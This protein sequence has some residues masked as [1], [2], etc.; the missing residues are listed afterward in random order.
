MKFLFFP[1]LLLSFYASAQQYKIY[2]SLE[3]ALKHPTEVYRLDLRLDESPF[4]IKNINRIEELENLE[5]FYMNHEISNTNIFSKSLQQLKKLKYFYCDDYDYR[6][7]A[8]LKK[9]MPELYIYHDSKAALANPENVYRI[10]LSNDLRFIK[11]IRNYGETK[12]F[13]TPD[14]SSLK[15]KFSKMVG[16]QN[17]LTKRDP[18]KVFK[19]ELDAYKESIEEEQ[20]YS[21]GTKKVSRMLTRI[22]KEEREDLLV[23]FN[24]QKAKFASLSPAQINELK[25]AFL[26][27]L[28]P[29]CPFPN[30][31][32]IIFYHSNTPLTNEDIP[33]NFKYFKKLEVVNISGCQLRE[34]P[35]NLAK[36]PNLKALWA[37]QN[38][39]M[40]ILP[41]T[42]KQ[43]QNLEILDI[44]DSKL[45]TLS[46]TLFQLPKLKELYLSN[47]HSSYYPS[48]KLKIP[49]V[50]QG[51]ETIQ[52]LDL[53]F[54]T[55]DTF[56]K[57]LLLLKNLIE[58][59]L[60]G[61]NISKLPSE[62]QSLT[63]L[64]ALYMNRNEL[65]KIPDELFEM[66]NLE[67]LS[68]SSNNLTEV[69]ARLANLTKL[70]TL[71]LGGNKIKELP[72][73]LGKMIQLKYLNLGFNQFS[74]LPEWLGNHINLRGLN[75]SN[76]KVT[77]LPPNIT[78]L[79]KLEF[80]YAHQNNLQKLPLDIGRLMKIKIL[81]LGSNKLVFLPESICKINALETL[82][83]YENQ[84][85]ELPLN[86]GNLT[87]LNLLNIKDNQLT[88]L[89]DSFKNLKNLYRLNIEKNNFDLLLMSDILAQIKTL[90]YLS[91]EIK[92]IPKKTL[93]VMKK[94]LPKCNIHKDYKKDFFYLKDPQY[95]QHHFYG[96]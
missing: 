30:L 14:F 11:E 71:S 27:E 81:N 65:K 50:I 74:K 79:D 91:L 22:Y 53:S 73:D 66:N 25:E 29:R 20:Y 82:Y 96:F 42:I 33:A 16:D 49:D 39:N 47:L 59:S 72:K 17:S 64:K 34:I 89:P 23:F 31:R 5:W 94:K 52:Y 88:K 28:T 12:Y 54:N 8:P 44:S 62:I 21:T 55:I 43:F 10:A 87:N 95:H 32:E 58:L 61:N 6:D 80:L 92:K 24:T 68:L 77:L 46:T 83:L 4:L 7:A 2:Y 37:S 41:S 45:D 35:P 38:L 1:L 63:K 26:L 84:L 18:K 85:E 51:G 9:H 15:E 76:N 60:E 56:P 48:L 13:I 86:I 78:K 40:K 36:I 75:I 90:K 67:V 69:P 93:D 3:E 57:G 70:H 19:K